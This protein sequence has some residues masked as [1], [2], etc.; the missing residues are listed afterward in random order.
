MESTDFQQH[1]TNIWF[2]PLKNMLEDEINEW[3]LIDEYELQN[4]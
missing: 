4:Q 3:F 1:C 2:N